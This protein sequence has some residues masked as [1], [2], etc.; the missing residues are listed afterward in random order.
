MSIAS[1]IEQIEQHLTDDY[2][3]LELAGADLTNVNKNI[4]NLKPTWKE[5]LLYFMNNGTQEVWNNWNKVSGTGT[6]LTLNNTEEASMK[7]VYKG[8]TSQTGTPTPTSPIPVQVVSGDNSIEVSNGDNTQSA[9]YPISLGVENLLDLINF[10][11]VNSATTITS[12]QTGINIKNNTSSGYGAKITINNLTANTDYYLSY[13]YK[14]ISGGSNRV[15]VFAGTGQSTALATFI[16]TNGGTFNTGNNTT[17]NIWFYAQIPGIAEVEYTNILLE[18]GNIKHTYTPYWQ[19]PIEL[20]KIGT[21]QD[22]IFKNTPNTTDY[23]SN[24]EDNVWYVKKE[25]GKVVLDGSEAGWWQGISVSQGLLLR[26]AYLISNV[27]LGKQCLCDYYRGIEVTES[28]FSTKRQN[29][30]IY[31]NPSNPYIDIIDNTQSD[32]NSFK[33]WLS[34]HNTTIYY[35][36]ATPT[37]ETI[38]DTTLISQLEEAK[39]S[40]ESQTNISQTNNDLPFELDV[41]ALGV[42]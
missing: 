15:P 32:V 7:L 20:C 42:M 3:V 21:Y 12:L 39:K 37:Y 16:N 2:S 26:G 24:L 28:D 8:N 38:T 9:S 13:N 17:I 34:T 6:S 5:R 23:D 1:R 10:T 27:A 29:G 19:K 40:Y 14:N 36:L 11:P 31:I 41:V 33:T 35:P 30:D 25:I 4:V 22:K 18:K